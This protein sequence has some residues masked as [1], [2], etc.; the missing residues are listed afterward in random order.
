M[1]YILEIMNYI[2]MTVFLYLSVSEKEKIMNADHKIL[3]HLLASCAVGRAVDLVSLA[4]W[5][6]ACSFVPYW[7]KWISQTGC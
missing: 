6:N 2:S 4:V 5:A 7:N 1:M 3:H